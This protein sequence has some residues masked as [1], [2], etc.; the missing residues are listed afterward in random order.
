[1]EGDGGTC[2]VEPRRE[3]GNTHTHTQMSTPPPAPPHAHIR[4]LLGD[5]LLVH[6]AED[7]GPVDLAR[8]LA[9][10]EQGLGLA[11]DEAEDLW[12]PGRE[13]GG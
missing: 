4:T 11:V 1:M 8:V 9:L 12:V 13:G 10:E 6:L 5:A 7:D 2:R 3:T